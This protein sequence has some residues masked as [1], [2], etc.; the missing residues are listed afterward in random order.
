MFLQSQGLSLAPKSTSTSIHIPSIPSPRSA[1]FNLNIMIPHRIPQPHP[2]IVHPSIT[3]AYNKPKQTDNP[4]TAPKTIP[5]PRSDSH[6]MHSL[7]LLYTIHKSP[8]ARTQPT[9]ISVHIHPHLHPDPLYPSPHAWPTTRA[10]EKKGLYAVSI[11][12]RVRPSRPLSPLSTPSLI[13]PQASIHPPHSRT[14][15]CIDVAHRTPPHTSHTH[16]HPIPI[17]PLSMFL[18]HVVNRKKSPYRPQNHG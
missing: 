16:S 11:T 10:A 18:T 8:Q 1:S 15:E 14:F 6:Q 9:Q 7:P 2:S 3:S 13:I 12:I 5:S 17:H 4:T